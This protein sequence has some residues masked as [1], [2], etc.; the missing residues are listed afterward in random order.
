MSGLSQGQ[1]SLLKRIGKSICDFTN[2]DTFPNMM[3]QTISNDINVDEKQIR[4]IVRIGKDMGLF[5]TPT[6]NQIRL[7][8]AGLDYF[9]NE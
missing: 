5:E 2:G 6:S 1:E 9:C 4:I 3:I 8:E 7:T